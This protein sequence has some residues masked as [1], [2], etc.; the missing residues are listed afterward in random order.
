MTEAIREIKLPT[1]ISDGMI[2]Q[3]ETDLKL[4][5]WAPAGEELQV[6]LVDKEYTTTVAPDGSWE[7][8]LSQL[9]AGGPYE[10]TLRCS[11][12]T[13]VIK[14]IYIGDIWVLGG[15]SN[16]EI[17]VSRTLDLFEEEVKDARCAGI[18]KFSVPQKYN[19]HGP[20]EEL[21]GGEW[22]EVTPDTVNS[23]S[24][25]G[26]FFAKKLYDKYQI[27]IGLIHTAIGGTPAEA[28]I[29]EAT[30]KK[31]DK[32]YQELL[33]QC[34]DDEYVNGT[35]LMEEHRNIKWYEELDRK[36]AGYSKKEEPW[37]QEE[38][39]VTDWS[40]MEIPNSFM[41]TE[42]ETLKGSVWFRK[43][44][45][46]P[47]SMAGK[48]AKLLLGTIIDGDETYLNGVKIGSIPYLYPPRRYQIPKGLLKAG[49]NVLAVRV[50][51]T[52]NIGGFVTD[53]PYF[54]RTDMEELSIAGTWKYKIGVAT[55]GMKP[56]TFFQY[57]PSGVFNNMIYPLRNH[58]VK[59]FLWYQGE[60]N[61]WEPYGYKE[62]FQAVIEDWRANWGQG[63]LPFNFVQLSNFCLWRLEPEVSGWARLREEQRRALQIP[64]TGM[65]VTIDVGQ[66]N[67]LHPW[68]KKSVGERLALWAMKQVFDEEIVCSGPIYDHME[69]EGNRIRLHFTYVGG[70]LRVKGDDLKTFMISGKDGKFL[71][72]KAQIEGATV[73]V[74]SDEIDEPVA[75]R[76]AWSDNPE[77]ANLF[78]KEGLPASPFTT[79]P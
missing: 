3:R 73:L 13:R 64:N 62:L 12:L 47:E 68:D 71:P 22:E 19:F 5:G 9:K 67:D 49:K 57:K 35:K 54:I 4:W 38:L 59:G 20:V 46:I 40:D 7:L 10:M 44:I 18:R 77:E 78:N 58:K 63:D 17:P 16:M 15:Q 28:W 37:Y 70:G 30:L 2:L 6:N 79:E 75:V 31:F 41:G 14:N 48:P 45:F 21:E 34:K 24:A 26:Y 74:W 65:A 52:Q 23:F 60:S 29:S 61:T 8:E 69:A 11:E 76:Y 1:L 53:M 66:Y 25:V 33:D 72:A 43:E 36:D 27:P 51:L 39:D 55:E 42:L 32:K 56:T 50:I